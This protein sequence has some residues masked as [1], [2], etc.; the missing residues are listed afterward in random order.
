LTNFFNRFTFSATGT[1]YSVRRQVF[2][3][4]PPAGG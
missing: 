4:A 1:L 3:L 2:P